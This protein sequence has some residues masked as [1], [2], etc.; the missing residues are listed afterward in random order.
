MCI[1]PRIKDFTKRCSCALREFPGIGRRNLT[2]KDCEPC[3]YQE[4]VADGRSDL[5]VVRAKLN[6]CCFCLCFQVRF[7]R[8]GFLALTSSRH[9]WPS[10]I[11]GRA[12]SSCHDAN[13]SHWSQESPIDNQRCDWQTHYEMSGNDND[14]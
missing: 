14:G 5:V 7:F 3:T 4:P 12:D 11:S 13:S 9:H 8:G 1:E 10:N 2:L 6:T